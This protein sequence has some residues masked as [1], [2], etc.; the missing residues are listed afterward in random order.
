MK[1]RDKWLRMRQSSRHRQLLCWIART[2]SGQL[3]LLPAPAEE[4]F[5]WVA[6]A[7]TL[8][9]EGGRGGGRE[10]EREREIACHEAVE[11]AGADSR[12][13]PAPSVPERPFCFRFLSLQFLSLFCFR[14]ANVRRFPALLQKKKCYGKRSFSVTSN[15]LL[16]ARG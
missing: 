2:A 11:R 6:S 14:T 8:T 12:K 16:H 5:C 1:H 10:G 4:Y 9:R 3:G 13:L 7:H 15:L